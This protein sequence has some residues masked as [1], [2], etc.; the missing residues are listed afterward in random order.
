MEDTDSMGIVSTEHGGTIP[1]VGGKHGVIKAL[2]WKQV[3]EISNQFDALNPYNRD[4]VPTS[5]LKLED[6]N[7]DD[8][9][10]RKHQRQLYC[11]A[12][13]A[14]RYALLLR[15]SAVSRP[16]SKDVVNNLIKFPNNKEDRWSE[17]GLGHLLNPTDPEERRSRM[18]RANMARHDSQDVGTINAEPGFQTTTGHWPYINY[19][20]CRDASPCKA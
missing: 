9:E 10:T 2:S 13:S 16:A 19:K 1:C 8:P 11:L 17:H 4:A 15:T 7:Y 6:D 14:K 18:D 3:E 20:S 12:I 5:I